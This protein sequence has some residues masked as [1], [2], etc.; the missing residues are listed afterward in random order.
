MK[1]L[2]LKHENIKGIVFDLGYSFSQMK[3]YKKAIQAFTTC[4][5]KNFCPS[6]YLYVHRA[7]AKRGLKDYEGEIEDLTKAIESLNEDEYILKTGLF[8]SL[9][10]QS[11]NISSIFLTF[12]TFQVFSNWLN[13]SAYSNI[14][15]ILVTFSVLVKF[16]GWL[17]DSQQ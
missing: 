5:E 4:I 17:N 7:S 9:I 2:K 15:L 12:L 1:N 6:F 3:D 8:S 11:S 14:W 16:K 10:G 13:D